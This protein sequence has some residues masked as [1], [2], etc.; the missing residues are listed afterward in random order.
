MSVAA[1]MKPLGTFLGRPFYW[2]ERGTFTHPGLYYWNGQK[3]V[4][5]I[6]L[7]RKAR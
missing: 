4:R 3:N 1:A 5:L 2:A 6:P 7:P